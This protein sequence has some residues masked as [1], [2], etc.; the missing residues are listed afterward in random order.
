VI[1]GANGDP[2]LIQGLDA[3][4][5]TCAYAHVLGVGPGIGKDALQLFICREG[6]LVFGRPRKRWR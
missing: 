6:R 5:D 3:D 2:V 1:R 4:V